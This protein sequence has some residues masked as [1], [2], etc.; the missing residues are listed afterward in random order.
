MELT[1]E[2]RWTSFMFMDAALTNGATNMKIEGA[3]DDRD[4]NY[5]TKYSDSW[6]GQDGREWRTET[7]WCF[8]G[9]KTF[10]AVKTDGVWRGW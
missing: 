1:S 7:V 8:P 2:S 3:R 10:L 4:S 6:M 5:P 9:W